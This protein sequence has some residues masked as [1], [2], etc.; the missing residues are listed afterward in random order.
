[1]DFV[2]TELMKPKQALLDAEVQT[3]EVL[4]DCTRTNG[5]TQEHQLMRLEKLEGR[6]Q[7]RSLACFVYMAILGAHNSMMCVTEAAETK[8][9]VIDALEKVSVIR[10]RQE[11]QLMQLQVHAQHSI[12]SS[13]SSPALSIILMAVG[14]S[15]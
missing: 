12:R 14:H 15:R 11:E 2:A 10:S 7:S 9:A 3:G 6:S 1:M 8:D 4:V 5:L 13:F